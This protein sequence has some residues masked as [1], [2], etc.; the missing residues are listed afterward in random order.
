M[1]EI[2]KK[3]KKNIRKNL[4]WQH[5]P[6]KIR[7]VFRMRIQILHSPSS[8]CTPTHA[9][10]CRI[11]QSCASSTMQKNLA[12]LQLMFTT[13]IRRGK[14]VIFVTLIVTWVLVGWPDY[15]KTTPRIFTCN[16]RLHRKVCEKQKHWMSDTSVGGKWPRRG[17]RKTARLLWAARKDIE[18]HVFTV[19]NH[20]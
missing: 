14:N 1:T 5:R 13:K 17:Q 6:T 12:Q 3:K 16:W 2:K 9:L 18:T 20:G 19:Y 8:T 4:V 15:F 11:S 10:S 7:S